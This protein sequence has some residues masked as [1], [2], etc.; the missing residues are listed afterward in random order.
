MANQKSVY[1]LMFTHPSTGPVVFYVGCTNNIHRRTLEH[2]RNP[3]DTKHAE[4]STDKYKFCR[5]LESQGIEYFLEV[6]APAEHITDSADEYSWIL[7]FADHNRDNNIL[8]YD[9]NPLT[10][11]RAGDFL[12]EMMAERAVRTPSQIRSYMQGREQARQVTLERDRAFGDQTTGR[13]SRKN[14][15]DSMVMITQQRRTEQVLEDLKR[16]QREDKRVRELAR[17]RAEQEAEWL[18]TGKILGEE[19][20][21]KK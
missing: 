4:Y 5:D 19:K 2:K 20:W 17:V 18:A 9:G 12:S 8:F 1:G 11:M 3:F 21:K 6:L 10:N 14:V 13:H 15:A 16:Q 7:K